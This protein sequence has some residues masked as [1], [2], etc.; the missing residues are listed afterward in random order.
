N[1][2]MTDAATNRLV[3]LG[4]QRTEGVE[5][6]FAGQLPGG[7]QLWSGF[8]WL[9][10]RMISSPAIDAGQ[11]VQGKR[12]TLTPKRSAMLWAAKEVAPKL[13]AGAGITYVDDRYANPGNTVTLAAYATVDAMVQYR[14]GPL[15]LQLNLNNLADRRYTVSGHGSS[16]NLNLPGAPRNAQL[17]ARYVF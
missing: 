15:E 4:V 13:R 12:P 6:T 8:A 5:A 7:W 14:V 11:P 3:P 2:K 1:I 16:P 9:D 17:T 10:A